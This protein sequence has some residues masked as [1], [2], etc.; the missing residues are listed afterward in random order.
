MLYEIVPFSQE[1]EQFQI[2]IQIDYLTKGEKQTQNIDL[3]CKQNLKNSKDSKLASALAVF[4]KFLQ[5]ED[6]VTFEL[7]EKFIKQCQNG[8]PQRFELL[9]IFLTMQKQPADKYFETSIYKNC[10]TRKSCRR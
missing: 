6:K 9:Q 5:E 8:N 3:T 10:R 2:K 1:L 4:A 7:C